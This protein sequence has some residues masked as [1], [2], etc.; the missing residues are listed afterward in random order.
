MLVVLMEDQQDH[1]RRKFMWP[2]KEHCFEALWG[3]CRESFQWSYT[4][5]MLGQHYDISV[6]MIIW[7]RSGLNTTYLHM[8]LWWGT[9]RWVLTHMLFLTWRLYFHHFHKKGKTWCTRPWYDPIVRMHHIATGWHWYVLHTQINE[10]NY[11]YKVVYA[12][13]SGMGGSAKEQAFPFLGNCTHLQ[14]VF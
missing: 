6:W 12:C 7:I 5:D 4:A 14:T 1:N 9:T 11:F 2:N 3:H 8:H 10:Q 13:S